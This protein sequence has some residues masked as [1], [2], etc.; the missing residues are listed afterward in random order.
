MDFLLDQFPNAIQ[1][2]RL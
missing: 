1:I 2:S